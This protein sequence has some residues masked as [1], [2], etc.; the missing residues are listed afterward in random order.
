MISSLSGLIGI[1]TQQKRDGLDEVANTGEEATKNTTEKKG[2]PKRS[3]DT[4]LTG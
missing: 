3:N 2:T 1:W 4:I